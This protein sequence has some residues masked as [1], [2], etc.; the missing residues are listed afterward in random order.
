METKKFVVRATGGLFAAFVA[1]GFALPDESHLERSVDIAA[2]I[3]NV[4]EVLRQ[5]A[6]FNEY[7]AWAKKDPGAKF[8]FGGA[9]TGAGS[10][11]SWTSDVRAVGAGKMILV[12]EERC[13]S[14]D[15]ALEFGPD[16]AQA[17]W[18]LSE[19]G[20][21]THVVYSFD[22]HAQGRFNLT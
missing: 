5:I 6:R 12:K 7:S 16:E 14:L 9:Q 15:V 2:P 22:G 17:H 19:A 10:K 4:H 13:T 21:Q 11:M 1:V 18:A 8:V 3:C 20:G